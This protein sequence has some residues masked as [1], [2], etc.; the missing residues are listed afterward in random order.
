MGAD[1]DLVVFDPGTVADRADYAAPA[2]PS[3]GMRHVLVGGTFVVRDGVAD[4]EARP[5][6]PIRGVR[7]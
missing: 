2:R 6:R 3:V 5:G 4:P 7:R 1:A